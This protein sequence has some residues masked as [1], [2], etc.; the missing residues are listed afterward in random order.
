MKIPRK[1]TNDSFTSII[2][3]L[4]ISIALI[5]CNPPTT[6]VNPPTDTIDNVSYVLEEMPNANRKIQDSIDAYYLGVAGSGFIGKDEYIGPCEAEESDGGPWEPLDGFK[7]SAI[8]LIPININ[9]RTHLKEEKDDGDVDVF[10]RPDANF[11]WLFEKSERPEGSIYEP[12][13]LGGEIAFKE[14]GGSINDISSDGAEYLKTID[15]KSI[16]IGIY[17]PWVSDR[18]HPILGGK[19]PEI[20]PIQQMWYRT[21]SDP[22]EL[23]PLYKDTI[24]NLFS[25]FDNTKRFND[26]TDFFYPTS[27]P[28]VPCLSR[29]WIEPPLINSFYI[30]FRLPYKKF[31]KGAIENKMDQYDQLVYN[32]E[33]PS[34]LNINNYTPTTS[35][36]FTGFIS[37]LPRI[38]VNKISNKYPFVSISEIYKYQDTI[39]GYLKIETSIAQGYS[40][41]EYDG[42]HAFLKVTKSRAIIHPDLNSNQMNVPGPK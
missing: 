13:T 19:Q 7:H 33:M 28:I 21:D 15:F 22:E 5:T 29:G 35:R 27:S 40:G 6:N 31:N 12:N 38:I 20:H 16:K 25:M 3:T 2:N 8:I 17:G 9:D 39:R 23:D 42:A 18:G 34:F 32:I 14:P 4:V 10:L 41:R 1:S 37:G 26:P 36:Q 24:Y 11:M 30:S